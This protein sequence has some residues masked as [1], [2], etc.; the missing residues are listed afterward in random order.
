MGALNI[1]LLLSVCPYVC[2]LF[3]HLS[4]IQG[5]RLIFTT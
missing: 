5:C 1:T 2:P 4:S 3:S